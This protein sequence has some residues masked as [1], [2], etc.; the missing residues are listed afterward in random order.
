MRDLYMKNGQGFV[1]L[2]SVVSRSTFND[3]TDIREQILR[4]KDTDEVPMILVGSKTELNDQRVVSREEG[5]E[6]AKKWNCPYLEISCKRKINIDEVFFTL[7][8][9]I[10]EMYPPKT[11]KKKRKSLNFQISTDFWTKSL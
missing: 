1:L 6:L 10:N 11:E 2:Y 3:L 7:I 5:I 4:V 9:R 8:R